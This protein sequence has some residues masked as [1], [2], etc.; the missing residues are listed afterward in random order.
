V[1]QGGVASRPIYTFFQAIATTV[2]ALSEASGNVTIPDLPI[3]ENA[4]VVGASGFS[5]YTQGTLKTGIVRILLDGDT[6]TPVNTQYYGSGPTGTRGWFSVSDA[7]DS[8]ADITLSVG[9]DGVT[10]F[11]LSAGVLAS[12][13]LADSS[14]Q[15][16]DNVSALTNDAAY[17]DAA[18]AAAAAPVQSVNGATG[19]VMLTASDV[20]AAT[21][22]QG[23]KA[24]SALQSVVA[25][26]NVT[27]DN[28]DPQNPVI[29]VSSGAG[30]GDVV[31][32]ASAVDSDVALFDGTTGKLLKDGGSFG[33]LVRAAVLT[34]LSTATSTVIAAT[35]SVLAAF[36]KLQA[37]ITDNLLPK[38]YIDGLQMQWV[39][40]T[41]LTVTSGAAYIEGSSKVLRASSAIAKTGL[42]LSASTWYHVYLYENAG[43]PDIELSTTAPAAPYN[44]TARSKTGDSSRRYVGSVRTDAGGNIYAFKHHPGN[45][46]AYMANIISAPF[47]V[48]NAG[49]ATSP[50][51]FDVSQ[52][53]PTTSTAALLQ[54]RNTDNSVA[55][56][57]GTSDQGYT[58]T[59]N[60]FQSLLDAGSAFV[61]PVNTSAS[62]AV[63][64]MF[65]ASPTGVCNVRVVGY[66]L[67]R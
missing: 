45:L 51:T 35:D 39:S 26:T 43:T 63:Q 15:P 10:T 44:G 25:G 30:S 21:T 57:F 17:V 24:D 52:L 4:N 56:V 22:A 46:V 12:L 42:S 62:Q 36:G 23:A 59:L 6:Q 38:G 50:T 27:V 58:L 8:T 61:A 29:N 20:G 37:Q 41:A 31:G 40:G 48:V 18:G 55:V 66:L 54:A 47:V 34:G 53:V 11:G 60:A 14:V 28:T 5:I 3:S 9:A 64:Y 32:P 33:S 13:A 2:D 16:G 19:T 65:R 1:G 67:D 49:T 7:L